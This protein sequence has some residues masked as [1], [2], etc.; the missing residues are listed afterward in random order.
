MMRRMS[1]RSLMWVAFLALLAVAQTASAL[2]LSDFV[3]FSGGSLT[4]DAGDE[5]AIGGHTAVNGNIGSNQDLFMQGNPQPNYPAQLNGSA[6]AGGNLTF[7]QD[8]TVG[9]SSGPLREVVA[10]GEASIGGGANIYGNLYGNAVTL[11]GSTGIRQ[12]GGVG[13]NVQYT[14]SYDDTSTSVVEGS[15]SSPSSKTFSLIAMPTATNITAGVVNQPVPAGE[16]SSL[17]VAPGAWG[18][19]STSAQNQTVLLSSGNY[20]FD[21]IDVNHGY[22]TLKIDLTS[23]QPINI[24]SVEGMDFNQHNVIMVTTNGG[25]SYVPLSSAPQLASLIYWETNGTFTMGGASD[26]EHNIWG[27]TLYASYGS[28]GGGDVNIGQYMD[29]Y[30]AAYA[31][32][33]FDTADHGK[34]TYVP[35]PEPSSAILSLIGLTFAGIS[36]RRR[37]RSRSIPQ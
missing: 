31:Y 20:S 5:T 36:S 28:P 27:G 12:V 11:G 18:A 34:W 1:R 7:G 23:G 25:V 32:D 22:F 2:T 30:G 19:L 8:L 26:G 17:T 14:T 37:R 15:V 6:Y 10:N 24:Y 4:I 35:I 3:I 29:W 33:S 16:Y 21:S 13:G 9:S